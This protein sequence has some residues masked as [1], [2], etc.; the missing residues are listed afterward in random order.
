MGIVLRAYVLPKRIDIFMN[1]YDIFLYKFGQV[2]PSY[3]DVF[4]NFFEDFKK[5]SGIDVN[6]Y[7]GEIIYHIYTNVRQIRHYRQFKIAVYSDLGVEHEAS[8]IKTYVSYFSGS[9]F[10]SFDPSEDYD[11]VLTTSSLKFKGNPTKAQVITV[12]DLVDH[13]DLSKLYS[14]IYDQ[15]FLESM[16]SCENDQII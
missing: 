9:I 4:M 12:S 13:R 10:S 16:D 5:L 8:I 14:A 6:D 15:N 1:R 2:N 3:I 7:A 11:I